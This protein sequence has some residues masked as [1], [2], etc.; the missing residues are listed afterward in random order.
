M[1]DA[2]A[3]LTKYYELRRSIGGMAGPK[4]LTAKAV[5]QTE[6]FLEWCQ[7][8]RIDDPESYIAWRMRRSASHNTEETKQVVMLNMLKS[9][10]AAK[11]WR[12][13]GG[14]AEA[15]ERQQEKLNEAMGDTTAQLVADALAQP[16]QLDRLKA[17]RLA[18]NNARACAT[19]PRLGGFDP[20]SKV[21]P[22]CPESVR[23]AI[24]LNAR[25][26]FDVVSLRRGNMDILPAVIRQAM[27]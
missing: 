18:E 16:P 6:D 25:Y 15:A 11:A 10:A 20:R 24:D 3:V 26:G 9:W 2:K 8:A 5:R 17:Q 12:E 7:R 4:T 13:W 21:C 14:F 19:E 1:P 27:R 23:C 22:T